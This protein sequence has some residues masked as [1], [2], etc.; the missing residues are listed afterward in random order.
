MNFNSTTNPQVLE[1]TSGVKLTV[2]PIPYLNAQQLFNNAI[3]HSS[4][5][6]ALDVQ[7]NFVK[8]F[9]SECLEGSA[10]DPK[11]L[12]LNIKYVRDNGRWE[13]NNW[14]NQKISRFGNIENNWDYQ[15][16]A[17]FV[18]ENGQ[19]FNAKVANP[20]E[21]Y[22]K[23]IGFG[24]T[25]WVATGKP[26]RYEAVQN[27]GNRIF[28]PAL[29]TITRQKISDI[30]GVELPL[31]GDIWPWLIA[32][33]EISIG[34]T[35]GAKKAL[36]LCCQGFICIA[37]LG[38]ANWSVPKTKHPETGLTDPS[39]AR[40]LLPE[41]A[42][43]AQGGRQMPIWYDQDDPKNNLKALMNAKR[44]G[45]LLT[46]ALKTAGANQQTELLWWPAYLGKGVDDV[47]VGL[48]K[49]GADVTQ[50]IEETIA[51]SKNAAI[52]AQIKR[53]YTIAQERPIESSTRGGYISDHINIRLEQGKIHA[54]IAG[55]GAGKSTLVRKIIAAWTSIGGFTVVITT[56]NKL[57]KQLADQANLPHRHD[58]NDTKVLTLKADADG[59]FVSC[60]DSLVR[61]TETIPKDRPLL[62][63]CEEADQ[64][65]NHATNGQTLKGKYAATQ[66]ALS[67][68][69]TRADAVILAEARI[70]EN[71]LKYLEQI[72]GKPTRVFIHELETQ[73]RQV[74]CYGGQVSGFEAL[75]L[76]RL[77][78]G[79]KLILTADS[80]RELEAVGRLIKKEL[81][82]LTGMRNDQKTSY[83]SEVA[84][85]TIH[86][87]EVLAREQLDYLLYSPSC[88]AGW[89]LSGQDKDGNTYQFDRVMGIFRVLPTSDQ[90]QMVARYRPDCPWDIYLS[91]T[92]QVSGD[93]TKGSPRALSRDMAAEAQRIAKGWGIAYDPSDRPPLEKIAR[94]HYVVATA[95]AGLEKRI[96]RYSMVQR[97]VE[98]GH[99]V[100]EEKLAYNKS[101]ANQMKGIKNQI[102]RDWS[103]LVASIALSLQDD[104]ELAKKLEQLEAPTP[105][106]SAKAE[107]I[108][109]HVRLS[110][111]DFD[112]P[113]ISYQTLSNYKSLLKGVEIQAA[114]QNIYATANIQKQATITHFQ[115]PIVAIHH[116]P[117]EADRA[118]LML[119]SG[120]LDLLVA[121]RIFTST[122]PE[123][124]ALKRT[125]LDR[126]DEWGR[127]FG[128]NFSPEQVPISFFTRLAK[129]LA[130]PI[131]CSRPGGGDRPRQY[132]VLTIDLVDRRVEIVQEKINQLRASHQQKSER[133]AELTQLATDRDRRHQASE[134]RF[135]DGEISFDLLTRRERLVG[136]A[137]K[138]T[139][140]AIASGDR[141]LDRISAQ[142]QCLAKLFDTRSRIEVRVCLLVSS[143]ARYE[144]MSTV[145]ISKVSS[146]E[147]V[148]AV[149][150][151]NQNRANSPPD[152]ATG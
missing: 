48:Q 102:D 70:P 69:L 4:E 113:E 80:Q 99:T 22:K 125:V 147:T 120:I 97:L 127:Y 103:N 104:L 86:P 96:N 51:T 63:F 36:S 55:T 31:E 5:Y 85:L 25:E 1:A 14:L 72:S 132:Q 121:G 32:H 28:Y 133:V 10:V 81:P 142:E 46:S 15:A 59:G 100:T 57:G 149:E 7:Q 45:H 105:E 58:Y 21:N 24:K 98:D 30:C 73:K 13:I 76:Q 60:L 93:E 29:D 111:I 47:I 128:Y 9:E 33:P 20:K 116:L 2:D 71:T 123:I 56:T 61:L 53:L 122:S 38:I 148:D 11:V 106:Q 136:E 8:R 23:S 139:G 151:E 64:L 82:H 89:D 40:V 62:V 41:L 27:G 43:L 83:L 74:T 143:L 140:Q 78:A 87:N 37:V 67:T 137:V 91:E 50:W 134:Q 16:A 44:E 152:L 88:K 52:Y 115:Q 124:L 26:R 79:E 146:M 34:I 110:G 135:Q 84:E 95:R 6:V 145:S 131:H 92:I 12:A 35:E 77:K 141:L 42:K 129:R 130:I 126:A 138:A 108:R 68:L 90:I 118:G 3:P 150:K 49:Q 66:Q 75:I 94:E 18:S 144:A 39:E 19:I 17:F 65:A 101:M 54:I 119:T 114:A 109:L 117:H 107:K 112:N